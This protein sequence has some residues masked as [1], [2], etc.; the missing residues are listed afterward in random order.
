MY[1]H[2]TRSNALF[3]VNW[4]TLGE[5]SLSFLVLPPLFASLYNGGNCFIKTICS[6]GSTVTHI[7]FFPKC[8]IQTKHLDIVIETTTIIKEYK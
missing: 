1:F 3:K 4:C 6:S 2:N 5:A 8:I 7:L